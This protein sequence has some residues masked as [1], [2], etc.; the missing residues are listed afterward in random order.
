[1][2]PTVFWPFI[3]Y[4]LCD[5]E[6]PGGGGGGDGGGEGEEGKVQVEKIN[7]KI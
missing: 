3:L 7:M 5:E 2:R 4:T 1:M 6:F